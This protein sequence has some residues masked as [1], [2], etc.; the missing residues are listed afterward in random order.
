MYTHIIVPFDGTDFS[1]RAI[2]LGRQLSTTMHAPLRIVSFAHSHARC[3]ELT[4][5]VK[6]QM[7]CI[8]DVEATWSVRIG[9]PAAEL[10]AEWAQA[11]GALVCMSSTG[12]SRSAPILG[13]VASAVLRDMYGPVLLLGPHAKEDAFRVDG[14]MVVCSDGSTVADAVLP[15]AAQWAITLP[16]E[17]WIVTVS[18]ANPQ[19][20]PA[21]ARSDV[22][23]DITHAWHLAHKLT[24]DIGRTA[25]HEALHS[26][27]VPAAIAGFA[28]DVNASLIV[29]S[30]HGATGLR[31]VVLGS[32]TMAV[33][34][35]APCPVLVY[36][37]AHLEHEG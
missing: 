6:S 35:C 1:G 9:D 23:T 20:V 10:A 2:A 18:D 26:S 14:P 17:P 28:N 11:P 15:L 37:P 8:D 34:H 27:H 32:V 13:S 33:V 19:L 16:V 36:R 3:D 29:M 21:E 31:R 7:R 24:H 30:T 5:A 4:A 22:A 12:R 25:Q